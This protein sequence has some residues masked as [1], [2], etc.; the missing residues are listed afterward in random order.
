MAATALRLVPLARQNP[1][2]AFLLCALAY[3]SALSMVHGRLSRQGSCFCCSELALA[4]SPA[5]G[6]RAKIR[7]Q[8]RPCIISALAADR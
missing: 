4:F 3:A 5:T 1:A 6:M 2:A 7:S 8:P